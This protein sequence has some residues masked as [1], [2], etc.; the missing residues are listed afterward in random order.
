MA[1]MRQLGVHYC[2][3][4]FKCLITFAIDVYM[5]AAVEDWCH[6]FLGFLGIDNSN[7]SF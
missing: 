3:V 1:N 2:Y 7:N 6:P 4:I 5:Y